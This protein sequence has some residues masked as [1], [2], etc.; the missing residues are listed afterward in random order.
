[1]E[2]DPRLEHEVVSALELSASVGALFVSTLSLWEVA[3]LASAG[4]VRF[5]VPVETWLEEALQTP[6]LNVMDVDARVAAESTSL[7]DDFRGDPVDRILVAS[8]RVH[9][10]HLYT[11]DPSIIS[12]AERGFLSVRSVRAS[13]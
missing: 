12:Y 2:G 1:M 11:A 3:T 8:A 5:S 4:R 10:G 6:G 7:P 13:S 9:G